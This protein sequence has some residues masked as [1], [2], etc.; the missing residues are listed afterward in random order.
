MDWIQVKQEDDQQIL[1]PPAVHNAEGNSGQ[2]FLSSDGN[3]HN[4]EFVQ[5]VIGGPSSEPIPIPRT[6]LWKHSAAFREAL[7]G[8]L[9]ERKRLDDGLKK[10]QL[11]GFL[12]YAQWIYNSITDTD[13]RSEVEGWARIVH[14]N[15]VPLIS[16]WCELWLLGDLLKDERICEIV[17]EEMLKENEN[18]VRDFAYHQNNDLA[19][20]ADQTPRSS[21]LWFWLM[22]A[23]ARV[24][25][26]RHI[27]RKARDWPPDM[28]I[29][30]LGNRFRRTRVDAGTTPKLSQLKKC[31]IEALSPEP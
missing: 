14:N 20:I 24:V 1:G 12:V 22:D 26:P 16:L 4:H 15:N 13:V 7:Q 21:V 11:N 6:L 10:R 30:V 27:E 25:H 29:G 28:V 9:S 8:S 3:L 23:M 18:S 2:S 31:V 17:M 5:V 19:K